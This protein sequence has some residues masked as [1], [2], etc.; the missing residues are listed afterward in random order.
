MID[1]LIQLYI[2][3]AAI[4]Y[5]SAGLV[6]LQL[7]ICLWRRAHFG[8]LQGIEH[9]MRS[10]ILYSAFWPYVLFTW[11]FSWVFSWPVFTWKFWFTEI[12]LPKPAPL[13]H[14]WNKP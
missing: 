12:T 5:L 3:N 6:T 11:I 4:L 9:E 8:T 2:Q 7:L 1:F 13:K 10:I 14:W